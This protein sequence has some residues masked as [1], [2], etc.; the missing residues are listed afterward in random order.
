MMQVRADVQLRIERTAGWKFYSNG[1]VT[2]VMKG[3]GLAYVADR[4]I[5][6]ALLGDGA[7]AACRGDRPALRDEP[8]L[9]PLQHGAASTC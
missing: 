1:N 2:D 6:R 9:T 4:L 7:P 8:T 5:A 3:M